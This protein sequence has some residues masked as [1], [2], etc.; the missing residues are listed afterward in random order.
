MASFI[1][2][3]GEAPRLSSTNRK[4]CSPAAIQ[5]SNVPKSMTTL[6]QP[7]RWY[8]LYLIFVGTVIT[9]FAFHH[10]RNLSPFCIGD[11]LINYTAGFVRRGLPGEVIFLSARL[12]HLGVSSLPLLA[13]FM[14]VIIFTSLL[15]FLFVLTRGVRFTY[16][17]A[18]LLLSPATLAFGLLN[19][20]EGMRK[21]ILLYAVL[22]GF[23]LPAVARL[24]S[25]QTVLLLTVAAPVLILSHELATTCM[26]YLFLV[27]ALQL[28]GP[29]RSWKLLLLPAAAT[30]AAVIAVVLH[31]GNLAIAQGVCS[32]IGHTLHPFDSGDPG[33]C[34]GAIVWLTLTPAQARG[35]TLAM[36]GSFH[37]YRAYGSF[38]S[39][40][41]LLL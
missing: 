20:S 6:S 32:S 8:A 41:S 19:P 31:P 7:R 13:F 16:A 15:C 12:L 9:Y 21:E 34:S 35:N 33:V 3:S 24:R 14:Q 10:L 37:Y 18:A 2:M 22:A 11:Y 40:P 17:L 28:G 36:I 30:L 26:P 1:V 27:A 5:S 39:P 29:A 23:C 4:P 25:W 38:W